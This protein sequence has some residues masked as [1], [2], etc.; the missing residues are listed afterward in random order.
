MMRLRHML[1]RSPSPSEI[2]ELDDDVKV[3]FAPMDALRDGAGGLDLS[4]TK[5]LK[6]VRSSSYSYFAD[7]DVLLAKVTPCF[8]NG[9]KAL[10]AR[11]CNGIG[12]A[13]S[14]VHVLRPDP[15]KIDPR[16]LLYLLSSEDFRADG[17]RSMTGAGGLR[18]VSE[19]ALLDYRPSIADL[20]TQRR[21]ADFLDRETARIDQLISKKEQ[22]GQIIDQ[23]RSGMITEAVAGRIGPGASSGQMN[24]IASTPIR[25]RFLL[26][27]S[28]SAREIER[29]T[30]ADH[31]TFAPM[32]AL[33]D[34]LGG[35]DATMTRPLGEVAAG[36]YNY[37]R[38]GDV[39]LA[40]V[41]PCFEN[42]KKALAGEL[43]NG[44]GFATSEVH[45]L[46]PLPGKLEARFLVY[47]SH[48][49]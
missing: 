26:Q 44:V 41:T 34:G 25:L 35:L 38:E 47:L 6:E 8:E 21:I 43:V 19:S 3:T 48:P 24:G 16:F 7:G 4:L 36:S 29:V 33:S 32:D 42:G 14:E 1:K 5:P 20:L 11:L 9:K 31:V 40:K 18:R 27:V 15:K 46:R 39:L 37:F 17:M 49:S 45:V 12:F 2:A 13:T 23:R 22:L 10:A 30:D 28:P